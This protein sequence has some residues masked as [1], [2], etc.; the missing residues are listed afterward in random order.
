MIARINKQNR[1]ATAETAEMLKAESQSRTRAEI[2]LRKVIDAKALIEQKIKARTEQKL[3]TQKLRFNAFV[4]RIELQ[5]EEEITKAKA[6]LKERLERLSYY[7]AELRKKE[8]KLSE[9]QG[10]L[11][12]ESTAKAKAYESLRIERHQL[13]RAEAKLKEETAKSKARTDL[14]PIKVKEK[15]QKET[16]SADVIYQYAFSQRNIKRKIALI[17]VIAIFSAITF[18]LSVSKNISPGKQGGKTAGESLLKSEALTESDFHTGPPV[19]FQG[20]LSRAEK[21][22]VSTP[23]STSNSEKN[24]ISGNNDQKSIPELDNQ[25]TEAKNPSHHR[26]ISSSSSKILQSSDNK[27]FETNAGAYIYYKFSEVSIPEGV[28]IKSVVLF[29]EHFEE[30][31][32][33]EEK[34]EWAVGTGWPNKPTVWAT[35]NAPINEGETNENVD[36]WDVTGVVDTPEKINT[37]QLQVKNNNRLSNSKTLMDYAYIAVEYD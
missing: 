27:R 1:K 13:R 37:L 28:I 10:Q 12:T 30:K 19:L 25:P 23:E 15:T 11:M 5:A 35:I 20:S 14:K 4:E 9:A 2:R 33:A 18:I 32:F 36:T 16:Q 3:L 29:I 24:I 17:A 21:R 6:Q 26:I 22:M 31:Q 7:K 34:L 8:E